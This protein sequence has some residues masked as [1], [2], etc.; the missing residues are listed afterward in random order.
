MTAPNLILVIDEG[1]TSTR[2]IVFDSNFN[3]VAQAQQAVALSYPNDGWVEQSAEE[4]WTETLKVCRQVIAEVG[5]VDRIAGIGITNQRETT[6]VWDRET[7]E[8]IAP[9]IVWQ[10]RRTAEVC[11]QMREAGHEPAIQQETGLL[12]DPYFSGTKIAWLLDTVDGARARAE[13]GE[14]A[15]GT[16][17]TFLIW[18]L[19]GGAVHATDVTN[20]SRT[21]LYPLSLAPQTAWSETML[22]LLNVPSA[23]MPTVR[24]SGANYGETD[25]ALFGRALP[26][27]S[28]IGDQ[29][30]ALVGQGCLAPGT[31]KITYGTGAFLV[32]N[33]GADRPSSD[34]RLLGTLGYA[35]EGASAAYALEG[36][37]F[38]AGTVVQW[39][40]DDLGLISDAAESEA[41]AAALTDNG[42]VFLVPAFTGL[43]APHWN[44]EARGTIVGLTRAA[45]AEH[46]VRA[47]LEAAAYQTHDL[48][49]AFAADGADVSL[50]RVDG[51]MAAN[52]W[53]MQFIADICARPVE[54]PD[55]MEMT[56][57]GAAALTGIQLGWLSERDWALRTAPGTR[58]E[59]AMSPDKRTA[60]LKG[61]SSALKQTLSS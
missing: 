39:L 6:L 47:G 53:L 27:L 4:I 15:F 9:A 52:D 16:V 12:I 1:T 59:P 22:A 38:N 34:N 54:R 28:A 57:L 23:L 51:G 24:P 13:A 35:I 49:T 46:L 50:L 36:A 10:D 61:W 32:A 41:K 43:G 7:G 55:F 18:K 3:P 2:A 17:D 48:L 21:M 14:L 30:A 26:I 8:P 29:Q 60:L 33:T 37:I 11:Q 40:R 20:A 56:A 45:R 44:A 58:F 5:G 19:T 42:G 31:A 25:P